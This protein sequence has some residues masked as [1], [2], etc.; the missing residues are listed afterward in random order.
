MRYKVVHASLPT[1]T[2]VSDLPLKNEMLAKLD[3]VVFCNYDIIF[4]NA[5]YNNVTF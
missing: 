1:S 2:F 4:I 5:D 3:N